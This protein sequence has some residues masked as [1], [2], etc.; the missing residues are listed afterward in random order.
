VG[1]VQPLSVGVIGCGWVAENGH[2]PALARI[3]ELE[4]AAFADPDRVRLEAFGG[5]FGRARQYA[6]HKSLIADP[7]V[8]AVAICVPTLLHA[9][10][11]SAAAEAGKHVLLEKPPALSL[12][13]WDR[14]A[15]VVAAAGVVLMIAL[16]MRWHRSFRAVREL[17]RG[18]A[19]GRVQGVRSVLANNVLD[20]SDRAEWSSRRG[21]GGGALLEMGVHH[22]D[23]FRFLLDEDIGEVFAHIDGDDDTLAVSARMRSGIPVSALFAQRTA[24]VNE[25]EVYGDRG[26]VKADPHSAPR[27]RDLTD[28]QWTIG[29]RMASV[30][31]TMS[32]QHAL[33]TRREGGFYVSSFVD[34]WR[35]F[36]DA[37]RNGVEVDVGIDSGRRLLQATLAT[38][39]SASEGRPVSC[40]DAPATL[41]SSS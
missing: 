1:T 24:Q 11:A 19:I 17:I 25:V 39:A 9:E 29:S 37:V 7:A 10:V 40:A 38:A 32:L 26:W 41:P 21:Q 5:R 35:H 6:D 18:G 12:D 16:N 14:L 31:A 15:D 20:R 22:L 34:E 30:R 8:D 33:R 23:L 27:C 3:P 36:L 28:K 4:P 2:V 13:G